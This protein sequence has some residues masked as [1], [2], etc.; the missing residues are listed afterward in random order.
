MPRPIR[1]TRRRCGG[2][3]AFTP[4]QAEG[5]R[6]FAQHCESCHRARLVADD[7]G[8]AVPFERW[9]ALVLHPSGGIV[10]G[11]ETRHRTGVMPYVHAEGAR[12]PSLRRLHVKRPLLTN[13]RA[14]TPE[15]VLDA[16]RLDVPEIHGGGSGRAL[17]AE[18]KRALAAFL[19]LL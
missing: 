13:G 4:H 15:A 11:S 18:Q 7:P 16:V 5:A 12:V 17:D 1:S 9:P 6:L 10:W 14:A 3:D 8:S 2:L 19:E